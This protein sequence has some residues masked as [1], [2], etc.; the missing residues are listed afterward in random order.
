MTNLV[1]YAPN[2]K[3]ITHEYW[4]RPYMAPVEFERD[5]E[6]ADYDEEFV[7]DGVAAS[8]DYAANEDLD[9]TYVTENDGERVLRWM[10]EDGGLWTTEDLTFKEEEK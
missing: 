9:I 3:K 4:L 5:P 8:T 10:D 1:A 6:I 2:G 7:A